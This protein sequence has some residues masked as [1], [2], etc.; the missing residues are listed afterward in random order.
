MHPIE[1]LCIESDGHNPKP[2]MERIALQASQKSLARLE[3]LS[4]SM[5]KQPGIVKGLDGVLQ[6]AVQIWRTQ[7][8]CATKTGLALGLDIYNTKGLYTKAGDGE[9]E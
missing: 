6:K 2:F 1:P 7:R 5:W 9:V 8:V 4:L 3:N